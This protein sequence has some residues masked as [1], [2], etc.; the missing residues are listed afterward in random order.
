MNFVYTLDGGLSAGS[1]DG[2]RF[3]F[4]FPPSPYT[5]SFYDKLLVIVCGRII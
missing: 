4:L 5:I 1:A 3:V 2:V